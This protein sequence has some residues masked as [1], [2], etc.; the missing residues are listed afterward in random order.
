MVWAETPF[1]GYTRFESG[2]TDQGLSDQSG[3]PIVVLMNIRMGG[4][5]RTGGADEQR[6]NEDERFR[7]GH[8][9]LRDG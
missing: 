9:Q 2:G 5:E 1:R 7:L 6:G 4:K 8:K 3:N